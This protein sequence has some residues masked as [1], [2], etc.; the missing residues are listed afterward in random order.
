VAV[1]VIA[2]AASALQASNLR[3]NCERFGIPLF[4][5]HDP[6]QGIE[7]VVAPEHRMIRPGT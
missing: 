3:R 6:L 7:H 4:D 1:R 5:T 2:D